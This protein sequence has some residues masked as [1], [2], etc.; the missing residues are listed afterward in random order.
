M[1]SIRRWGLA[2]LRRGITP[3]APP[4]AQDDVSLRKRIRPLRNFQIDVR[5]RTGIKVHIVPVV[6]WMIR[7]QRAPDDRAFSGP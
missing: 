5:R 4:I 7:T 3:I 2:I 6:P 1:R